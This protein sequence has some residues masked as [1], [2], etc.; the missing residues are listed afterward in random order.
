MV[1]KFKIKK[2]CYAGGVAMNVKANLNITKLYRNIDLFVPPS[3]DESSQAMGAC[4]GYYLT[5]NKNLNKL[6]PLSNAYLGPSNKLDE[7]HIKKINFLKTKKKY[8]IIYKNINTE[9]A[10]Q[11]ATNKVLGR[12][13]GKAEFGARSL[14]NRSI[15][16]SPLNNS[17]KIKINENVKNRDFWMPFAASIPE[18][19]AKKYFYI[20]SQ[21]ENYNYM[22]NCLNTT[23]LKKLRLLFIHMIKPADPILYQKTKTK[24]MRTYWQIWKYYRC[25]CFIKYHLIFMDTQL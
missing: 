2:I 21:I 15:L 12:F 14:G 20:K 19:N 23:K 9:A 22:T 6:K 3:P 4:Y 13:C 5:K 17:I 25:I 18:K 8:K 24:I 10:K 16:A 7:R 11:L 1:I